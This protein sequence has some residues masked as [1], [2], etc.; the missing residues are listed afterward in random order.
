MHEQ[1]KVVE[2]PITYSER[3]GRSKLSVVRDGARFLNSILMT[4]LTYNPARILGLIGVGLVGLGLVVGALAFL[5]NGFNAKP[6]GQFA[7]L[8]TG[9]VLI[10]AGVNTFAIGTT[11]NYIVSLFHKR[12]IRQGLLGRP[13]FRAPLNLILVG[14]ALARW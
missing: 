4:A 9:L 6:D 10:S 13:I 2:V 14:W 11:F 8:F 5:L 3:V 7:S 12:Q 1:I